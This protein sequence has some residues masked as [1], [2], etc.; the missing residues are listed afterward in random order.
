MPRFVKAKT[1]KTTVKT[2]KARRAA[3]KRDHRGLTVDEEIF[4]KMVALNGWLDDAW[5]AS[6]LADEHPGVPCTKWMSKRRNIRERIEE[7]RQEKLDRETKKF[8]F[9][10]DNVSRELSS[11]AFSDIRRLYDQNGKLIPPNDLDER[12]AAA[13]AGIEVTETKVVVSEKGSKEPIETSLVN[14]TFKYKLA[15]KVPALM[16]AAKILGLIKDPPVSV[17]NINVIMVSKLSE[18]RQR[19]IEMT[20]KLALEGQA[21]EIAEAVVVAE[22]PKETAPEGP[23][24]RS[25]ARAIAKA[26]ESDES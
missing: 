8:E 19:H 4:C 1:N 20:R 7:L 16:G 24:M 2:A 3:G 12:T 21:Q 6:G 13:V 10:V 22:A 25:R 5:Q 23:L 15:P 17:N 14:T 18:A 11:V 9:S 26:Q